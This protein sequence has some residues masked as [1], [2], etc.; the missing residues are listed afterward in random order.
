M[1]RSWLWGGFFTLL[2][3]LGPSS[4]ASAAI[5]TN[6][7]FEGD[8]GA[9]GSCNLGTPTGWTGGVLCSAGYYGAIP[10]EG[11]HFAI[12]GGGGD[13]PSLSLSQTI[14]SLTIGDSYTV[15][16]YLGGENWFHSTTEQVL[17][18]MLSGSSTGSQ[19]YD[20]PHST[21]NGGSGGGPLWDHW[22]LFSYSFLATG[23]SAAIKFV[24]VSSSAN[25]TGIDNV[26]IA[27]TTTSGV[28]EPGTLGLLCIGVGCLSFLRYRAGSSD[29]HTK[30]A[31]LG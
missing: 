13:F 16:F 30:T 28:P 4:A 11:T 26:S 1:G 19:M 27:N 25:D 21:D 9:L 23:T 5:I 17:V 22:T 29:N 31:S 14:T 15:S 7:G 12:I 3:V 6:G 2:L 18:S 8:G 24:N 10:P 20:A